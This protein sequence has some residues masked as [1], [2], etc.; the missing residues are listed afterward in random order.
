MTGARCHRSRLVEALG[1]R[2]RSEKIEPPDEGQ[3]GRVVASGIRGFEESFAVETM[4]LIGPEVCDRLGTAETE[5][6][7]RRIIKGGGP[8]NP[9]YLALEELGRAVRTMFI[10]DY[11]ASQDL[12]RKIHCL[13]RPT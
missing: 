6:V 11:L 4:A 3:I 9:V 7:L 8:K 13:H 1:R 12:R 2:C 10:C 5:Q